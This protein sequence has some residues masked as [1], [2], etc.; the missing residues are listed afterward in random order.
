MDLLVYIRMVGLAAASAIG[1][2]RLHKNYLRRYEKYNYI[3]AVL[4]TLWFLIA[5]IITCY[6]RIYG[7]PSIDFTHTFYRMGWPFMLA[8]LILFMLYY[9]RIPK[10]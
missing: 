4:T 3:L 10:R 6:R 7:V 9:R 1:L 2:W 5:D 8:T